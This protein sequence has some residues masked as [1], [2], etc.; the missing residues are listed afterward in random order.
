MFER[1]VERNKTVRSNKV[2]VIF[3]RIC[4]YQKELRY[5]YVREIDDFS[6]SVK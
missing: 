6:I 1:N 3:W 2:Y 4:V 5:T